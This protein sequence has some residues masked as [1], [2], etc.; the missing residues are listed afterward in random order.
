M[1][2]NLYL[3]VY[4][5]GCCGDLVSSIIDWGYSDIHFTEK[6]MIM[7]PERE[8]LKQFHEF[9]DDDEKDKYIKTISKIYKSIPSHDLNYHERKNHSFIGIVS[10]DKKIAHWASMRFKN[11]HTSEMWNRILQSYNIKTTEDYAKLIIDYSDMLKTKTK[12]IL[13]LERIISGKLIDDLSKIID[14]NFEKIDHSRYHQWLK[15]VK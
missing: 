5:G 1:I 14:K 12:N 10:E 15:M 2:N 7:S 9:K 11:C 6:R 3:V 13:F 4:M 8:R